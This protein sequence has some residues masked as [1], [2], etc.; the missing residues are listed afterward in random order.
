MPL[1]VV[2][3]TNIFRRDPFRLSQGFKTLSHLCT[4]GKI[5]LFL[6]EIVR[7]EFET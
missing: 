3:N 5:E 1:R 4:A 7:R 2:L 6:P